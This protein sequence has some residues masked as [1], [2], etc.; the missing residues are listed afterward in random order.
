MHNQSLHLGAYYLKVPSE[1]WEAEWYTF[2]DKK[3]FMFMI[4][5]KSK[6]QN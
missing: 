3:G 1:A 6:L 2:N 5:K 4:E